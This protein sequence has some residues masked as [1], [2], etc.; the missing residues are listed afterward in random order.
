MPAANNWGGG[1]EAECGVP[2]L[3]RRKKR[4]RRKEGD[5]KASTEE[6]DCAGGRSRASM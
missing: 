6:E 4:R 1:T 2:R 5:M 3:G